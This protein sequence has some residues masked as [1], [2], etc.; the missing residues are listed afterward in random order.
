MGYGPDI[1]HCGQ[2][3]CVDI[4]RLAEADGDKCVGS[5][6]HHYPI[7]LTTAMRE[8]VASDRNAAGGAINRAAV[9]IY[10]MLQSAWPTFLKNDA[11]ASR[12][13]GSSRN[14]Q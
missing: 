4:R 2:N 10:E 1:C 12:L 9:P 11:I 3:E 14:G 13:S 5:G 6:R 8:P 7:L